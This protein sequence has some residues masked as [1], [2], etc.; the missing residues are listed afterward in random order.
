MTGLVVRTELR[1]SAAVLA[2]LL[3]LPFAALAA[4][5][6][7]QGMVVAIGDA[8]Q[9][10]GILLPVALGIGAWQAGRDRRSRTTELF[11]TMPRP[12]W[13]R[14]LHTGAALAAAA[15]AGAVLV[16]TGLTVYGLAVG[17]YVP[18]T[19][20]TLGVVVPLWIVAA[21]WLGA[22]I[23]RAVP[24]RLT[25]PLVALAGL[26]GLL[27]LT[28]V[29]D[30]E[31][32]PDGT[33][34][35]RWLLGPAT[36]IG[37]GSFESL[38]GSTQ[39]AQAV[40]A[41]ACAVGAAVLFMAAGR[42]RLLAAVPIVLGVAVAVSLLPR[43]LH[44]AIA[45]D[46]GATELVCTPDEPTVCARRVHP[47]TLDE[48][49]GPGREA[50]RIMAAKLPN[51]PTVVAETYFST[52]SEAAG[53]VPRADTVYA[54]IYDDDITER[55]VLWTL[56]MGAGTPICQDPDRSPAEWERYNTARLVAAAWLLGEEPL[57]PDD[58][59]GY[60]GGLPPATVSGPAYD[61]LLAAPEPEQRS[62]V[63]R[64]REAELACDD[65]DRLDIL[66]GAAASR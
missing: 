45:V 4:G 37:L 44:E 43:Q 48:L 26:V 36:G 65:R 20:A 31:G 60:W 15:I 63:A 52:S 14:L 3:A 8:R 51:A 61:A 66:D 1:R 23:G 27:A 5:L 25:A 38:T 41:L 11:G 53:P 2:A 7:D 56:L 28:I 24:T 16:L 21:L 57:P 13:Q 62:R 17:A 6:P 10:L 42:Y 47:A 58:V 18:P 46:D 29:T 40:W 30:P 50:L 35:A 22:A 54:E 19:A 64:L 59:D 12:L 34:P 33:Y 49:E 9:E 32:S 55:D 39:A